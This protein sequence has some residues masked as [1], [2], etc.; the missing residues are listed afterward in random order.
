MSARR[1]LRLVSGPPAPAAAIVAFSQACQ[2]A[3]FIVDLVFDD[4]DMDAL[5]V[6]YSRV[7][8]PSGTRPARAPAP[9]VY[10][11]TRRVAPHALAV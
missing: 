9:V 6:A 4:D 2:D 1:P 3:D 5:G 8:G 10:L 7:G 11:P